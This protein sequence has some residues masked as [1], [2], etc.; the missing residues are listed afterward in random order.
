MNRKKR[1]SK[2]TYFSLYNVFS[3][4]HDWMSVTYFS[5]VVQLSVQKKYQNPEKISTKLKFD[6]LT[7]EY[8][9]L[10][11]WLGE[12]LKFIMT[13]GSHRPKT[14]VSKYG[15]VIYNFAAFSILI[16]F[17]K[18]KTWSENETEKRLTI[19]E[20]MHTNYN[21]DFLIVHVAV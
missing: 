11:F 2:L 8:V 19:Y 3:Q 20:K 9:E 6:K 12:N 1:K 5:L 10:C 7:Q 17:H 21:N 13:A 16:I 14:N 15:Q 18:K 4:F